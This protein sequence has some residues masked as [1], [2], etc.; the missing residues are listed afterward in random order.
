MLGPLSS[1]IYSYVHL[2]EFLY[3]KRGIFKTN[4]FYFFCKN[5]NES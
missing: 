4:V 2:G 3:G 1:M 5:K